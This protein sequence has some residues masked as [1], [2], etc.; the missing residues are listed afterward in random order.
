MLSINSVLKEQVTKEEQPTH[1]A[2]IVDKDNILS[3]SGG[4]LVL[5]LSREPLP[6]NQHYNDCYK[7]HNML[8]EEGLP[9][10]K[11]STFDDGPGNSIKLSD[12][13]S[14]EIA[15]SDNPEY[16]DRIF[17]IAKSGA[18]KSTLFA[19][20]LRKY[21]EMYPENR[22]YL[23]SRKK[24]DKAF[25][26]L[27][28]TT[29]DIQDPKYQETP[30]TLESFPPNCVV[31]LDDV[32]TFNTKIQHVVNELRDDLYQVGR[33]KN[34]TVLCSSHVYSDYNKTKVAWLESTHVVVAVSTQKRA[35][36]KAISERLG[37]DLEI[38]KNLYTLPTRFLV[39]S[40]SSPDWIIADHEAHMIK[41]KI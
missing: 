30:I 40:T 20:Y 15:P 22:I 31:I 23:I 12:N 13:I 28:I 25:N 5:T 4:R 3:D 9:T 6:S 24:E 19:S 26:G 35:G 2:V 27:N 33:S 1:L 16:P 10:T 17:A 7:I 38:V 14:F 36:I 11:I 21:S 29:I 8:K 34:I 41:E 32:G 37:I 18:G 39:F